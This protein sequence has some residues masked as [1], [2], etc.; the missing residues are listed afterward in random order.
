MSIRFKEV[1]S[2]ISAHC[3]DTTNTCTDTALFYDDKRPDGCRVIDVDTAAEL[4]RCR[5]EIDDAYRIAVFFT[6]LRFRPAFFRFI[7]AHFTGHPFQCMEDMI[8]HPLFDES[9]L[10]V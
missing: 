5:S 1:V 2:G 4:D 6:E 9:D 7:D 10:L 8:V 3:F